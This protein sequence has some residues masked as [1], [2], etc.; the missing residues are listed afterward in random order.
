MNAGV[1]ATGS[2]VWDTAQGTYDF[3]VGVNLLGLFHSVTTFMPQLVAQGSPADLVITASM[4]GMV[5][6]PYSG[7]YAASKRV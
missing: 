1:T 2:T 5:A 4:A 3:V 6:S 7:V